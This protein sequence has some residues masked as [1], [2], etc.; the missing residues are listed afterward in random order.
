MRL[1]PRD[2]AA[3]TFIADYLGDYPMA[4]FDEAA[5]QSNARKCDDCQRWFSSKDDLDEEADRPLCF[6]CSAECE[7]P[8]DA[9]REWG[10][11]G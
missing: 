5:E 4:D 6:D 2:P 3:Q 1:D 10:T 7:S 11:W 9:R 8:V